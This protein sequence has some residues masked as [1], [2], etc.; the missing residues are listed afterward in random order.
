MRRDFDVSRLAHPGLGSARV[1]RAAE[2][3]PLSRTFP[4]PL[5]RMNEAV[6][7][8]LFRR[9]AKTNTRDACAPQT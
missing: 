8:R 5:L 4:N 6:R 9:D 1:S 7:K 2:S 3:V